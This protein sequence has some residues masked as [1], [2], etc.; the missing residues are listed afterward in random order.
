MALMVIKRDGTAVA[1]DA[2]K[3][4]AAVLAAFLKDAGGNERAGVGAAVRDTAARAA[5]AQE[6]G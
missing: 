4:L 5:G 3:I 2:T 1:F 6:P